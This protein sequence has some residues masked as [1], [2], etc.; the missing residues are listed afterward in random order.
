MLAEEVLAHHRR[1]FPADG[2]R[3]NHRSLITGGEYQWRREGEYHLFNPET[4]FKLQHATRVR[5][6]DIVRDYSRAVDE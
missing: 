2:V 3:A 4:V 5:R 1:A 6:Y